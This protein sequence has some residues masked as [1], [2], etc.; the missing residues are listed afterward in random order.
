MQPDAASSLSSL[1][2]SL[3]ESTRQLIAALT[4]LSNEPGRGASARAQW[5]ALEPHFLRHLRAEEELLLPHFEL[6]A[7][8]DA[9]HI[10]QAHQ[11]MR[12]LLNELGR[13]YEQDRHDPELLGR[14]IGLLHTCTRDKERRLYGWADR[15]LRPI[16]KA[17]LIARLR[18]APE[19]AFPARAR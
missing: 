14:L 13:G 4:R 12:A 7:P 2:T 5:H 9:S 19:Q 15:C 17:E 11:S 16:R 8:G 6:S 18:T 10:R 3:N 1:Q